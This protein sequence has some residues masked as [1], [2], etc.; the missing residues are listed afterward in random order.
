MGSYCFRSADEVCQ[1]NA[2]AM[3]KLWERAKSLI[4]VFNDADFRLSA[5]YF[6]D[7]DMYQKLDDELSDFPGVM[8][9]QLQFV[10]RRYPDKQQWERSDL[11]EMLAQ[12]MLESQQVAERE[13]AERKACKTR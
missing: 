7:V 3:G 2:E 11:T 5:G 10:M 1:I 9:Y 4:E 12:A 6:N 8:F 13:R